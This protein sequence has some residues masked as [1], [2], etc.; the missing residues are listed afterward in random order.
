M[1]PVHAIRTVRGYA[2]YLAVV[3]A[4]VVPPSRSR[5]S[6]VPRRCPEQFADMFQRM[7]PVAGLLP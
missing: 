1:A 3:A 4:V 7:W 5:H 6:G 2:I